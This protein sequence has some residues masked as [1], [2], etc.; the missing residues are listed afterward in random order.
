M[1]AKNFQQAGISI[2]QFAVFFWLFFH[3]QQQKIKFLGPREPFIEPSMSV[4]S[5]RPARKIQVISTAL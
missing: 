5:V 1:H 4:P 3:D 2:C